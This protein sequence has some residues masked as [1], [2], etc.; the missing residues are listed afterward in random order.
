M[1]KIKLLTGALLVLGFT[2]CSDEMEIKH[3]IPVTG[4]EVAFGTSLKNFEMPKSRTIYGVPG[5]ESVNNY[6]ATHNKLG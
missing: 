6:T 3:E 5:D 2:A 1:K 4:E